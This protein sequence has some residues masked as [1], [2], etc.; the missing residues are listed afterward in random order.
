[1]KAKRLTVQLPD[2]STYDD[3]TKVEAAAEAIAAR[4][5]APGRD[6]GGSAERT[7]EPDRVEPDHAVPV[8]ANDFRPTA[9][10]QAAIDAVEKLTKTRGFG[11]VVV[12]GYAGVGK[13]T[14]LRVFGKIYG[15]PIV[16]TPTGK[17]ALRVSEASGLSAVTA[18]RWLYTPAENPRTGAVEFRP[19]PMADMKLPRC[20]LVLV[21]E[22]SMIGV[23]TW[24]D[25]LRLCKACDLRV[26]LIGDGFQL[27]PVE[28][29]GG[30]AT[31]DF[32]TMTPGFA[33]QH[34]FTRVELTEVLRQAADSPVVRASMGLRAGEGVGALRELPR[35]QLDQI[36]TTAAATREAGG[37]V[38][39]HSNACRFRVNHGMRGQLF[40]GEPPAQPQ[41][42]ET[43]LCL[44]NN[45]T[46]GV[47]NGE[48]VAF[49]GWDRAPGEPQ[50]VK[51]RYTGGEAWIRYGVAHVDGG[52][53]VLALEELE[54]NTGKLGGGALQSG[55]GEYARKN[56]LWTE[57]ERGKQIP[58]PYLQANYGYALTAHKAQGSEWPYALVILEPSVRLNLE[59]GAR[60]VYTAVTRAKLLAAVYYGRV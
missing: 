23:S 6:G 58:L 47:Y 42:G 59:E 14:M 41:A 55:A 53:C 32:S 22:A 17:A 48:Q 44:K 60:W 34:G 11:G 52:R 2:G 24:G 40:G 10:Q 49:Q 9:G 31:I 46:L 19:R 39:C 43:L 20:R 50:Q 12:T 45:Y 4:A 36:G 37:V 35:V 54:G 38:I 3:T 18:H 5:G 15:D 27:P 30:A 29:G 51:D 28:K 57:D 13:T 1:M 56:G 8:P 16:I 7:P 25:I 33:T 21:D 26:V